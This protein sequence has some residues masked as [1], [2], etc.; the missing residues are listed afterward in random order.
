MRTID[1][2]FSLFL[3]NFTVYTMQNILFIYLFIYLFI[4]GIMWTGAQVGLKFMVVMLECWDYRCE[5]SY[6]ATC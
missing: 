5:P 6:L 2:T 1:S 3:G 4:W